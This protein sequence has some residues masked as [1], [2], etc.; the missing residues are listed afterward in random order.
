MSVTAQSGMLSKNPQL[1]TAVTISVG[2]T[3]LVTSPNPAVSIALLAIP[4][5]I[6]N[7]A[8]ISSKP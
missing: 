8:I 2:R 3:V 7:I 5:T 1:S 4:C 6:V